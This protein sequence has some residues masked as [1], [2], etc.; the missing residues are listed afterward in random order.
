MT[1]IMS[2]LLTNK[3][4]LLEK[5]NSNIFTKDIDKTNIEKN[6]LVVNN[7]SKEIL[8]KNIK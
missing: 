5:V 7:F 8:E 4:V 1:Y 3:I 6:Y 2:L